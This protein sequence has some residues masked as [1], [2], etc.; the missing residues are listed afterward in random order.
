MIVIGM[1]HSIIYIILYYIILILILYY[2]ILYDIILYSIILYYIILYYIF[3]F[4]VY[5]NIYQIMSMGSS[6][7]TNPYQLLSP[8]SI[9]FSA[10]P[11]PIDTLDPEAE[12]GWWYTYPSEKY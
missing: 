6:R 11:T 5:S 10:P 3:I 9:R 12:S 1:S 7:P 4:N 8:P 2:I